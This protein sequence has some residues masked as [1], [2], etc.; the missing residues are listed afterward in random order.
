MDSHT[1]SVTKGVT[2]RIV[3]SVTTMG[4]VYA[5]TGDLMLMA[6]VG[7]LE[8]LAKL[9]FYYMHERAWERVAWGKVLV[10]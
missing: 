9:T 1:R 8:V 2:W 3:A 7:V 6:E 4:L 10:R 5:F